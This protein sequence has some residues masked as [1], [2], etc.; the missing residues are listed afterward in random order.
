MTRAE[1]DKILFIA[2]SMGEALLG[3]GAE[4]ARVE[5]TVSRIVLSYGAE[6]VDVFS[7]PSTLFATVTFNGFETKTQSRRIRSVSTDMTKLDRLNEL[8]REICVSTPDPETVEARIEEILTSPHYPYALQVIAYALVAGGF[9]VFF[10]GSVTD[11]F[12]AAL[13]GA[14]LRFIESGFRKLSSNKLLVA[15]MWSLT[16]G[17][18]ASILVA[19]QIGEHLDM[20]SIGCIML[21]IPGVAFTNSIRDLFVGD[22]ITGLSRFIEAVVLAMTIALGF[23]LAGFVH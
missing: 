15:L 8:S 2:V 18:L 6:S 12:A 3:C 23:T 14:Q 1:A 17:F 10:G 13:L 9:A 22:T 16:G 5:D 4:V 21:F 19:F 7:L 11:G 20:I